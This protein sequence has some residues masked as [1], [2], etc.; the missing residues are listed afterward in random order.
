[1]V[2]STDRERP[3]IHLLPGYFLIAVLHGL[4]RTASND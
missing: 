4:R 3:A 1:V 2:Q